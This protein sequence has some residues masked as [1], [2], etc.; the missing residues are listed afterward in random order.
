MGSGGGFVDEVQLRAGLF[1]DKT[2]TKYLLFFIACINQKMST[3]IGQLND[4]PFLIFLCGMV[5]L[6]QPHGE[7][8]LSV[9][10]LVQVCSDGHANS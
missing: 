9:L 7:K 5:T 3:E 1:L 10:D 2:E 4:L 8:S 6:G